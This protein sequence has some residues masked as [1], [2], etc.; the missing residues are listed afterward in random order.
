MLGRVSTIFVCHPHIPWYNHLASTRES[1]IKPN[2]EEKYKNNNLLPFPFLLSSLLLVLFPILYLPSSPA[3]IHSSGKNSQRNECPT[4]PQHSFLISIFFSILLEAIPADSGTPEKSFPV[5]CS[6]GLQDFPIP[7][8]AEPLVSSI[9][10]TGS[11][12]AGRELANPAQVQ[13]DVRS[14]SGI[15]TW[16]GLRAEARRNLWPASVVPPHRGRAEA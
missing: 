7:E 2:Q 1:G 15:L 11:P 5:E 10:R 3:P 6:P 4:H 12:L 16:L 9:Q 13:A 8:E 14:T